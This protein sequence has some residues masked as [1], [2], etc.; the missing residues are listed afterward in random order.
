MI[1]D[2]DTHEKWCRS[3]RF[4]WLTQSYGARHPARVSYHPRPPA[5]T[6][7]PTQ[8]CRVYSADVCVQNWQNITNTVTFGFCS[9]AA[10]TLD[11]L[12][13]KSDIYLVSRGPCAVALQGKCSETAHLKTKVASLF[14]SL[15][16]LT[17]KKS[18]PF[19]RSL[20]PWWSQK[21]AFSNPPEREVCGNSD[22]QH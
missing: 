21:M 15:I 19:H 13:E 14:K 8:L 11:S 3:Q 10:S 9:A 20:L 5:F 12:S 7:N 4:Q 1:T 22:L 16:T 18:S 17:K 6:Q 2:L